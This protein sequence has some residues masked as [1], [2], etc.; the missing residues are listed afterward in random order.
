MNAINIF[1]IGEPREK[2]GQRQGG[3]KRRE[4]GRLLIK[5]CAGETYYYSESTTLL[6]RNPLNLLARGGDGSWLLDFFLERGADSRFFFFFFSL[7]SSRIPSSTRENVKVRRYNVA[8]SVFS[9]LS[10]C[11]H[12]YTHTYIY[13]YAR[14]YIH[15]IVGICPLLHSVAALQKVGE[16]NKRISRRSAG[17][18]QTGNATRSSL[19]HEGVGERRG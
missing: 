2:F 6:N 7:P 19:F 3:S 10:C 17:Y 16:G 15:I 14:A 12:E 13:I 18:S 1:F 8:A 5:R 9:I 11:A 4:V